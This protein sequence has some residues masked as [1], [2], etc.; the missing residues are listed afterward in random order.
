MAN[1]GKFIKTNLRFI[2]L[3]ICLVILI[4]IG[5]FIFVRN[6]RSDEID[7][8]RNIEY[9]YFAMYSTENKVGVINSQG[10]IIVEPNYIDIYIPNPEK[11]VF[12]CFSTETEYVILNSANE[13]LFGD[14][15][16]VI[17]LQTSEDSLDFEKYVLRFK[18]DNKYGLINLDGEIVLDAN[19]DS[20][21][22]LEYKPGELLVSQNGKYGVVTS[23]G[24]LKIKIEYDSIVGDEFYEENEKYN[25]TGYI[26]GTETD[27]GFLYGYLDS[28]GNKVLDNDFESI[29]RV[30]KYNDTE[31]YLI[32]MNNG[33]RGVYKNNREIISQNY[34]NII[35]AE[36][37][38]IF[39]VRRNS[40][41]GIFNTSGDEIL[42]VKYA[43]Y[44]L[45]G[46]YISA[47]LDDGTKEL[48][49]VNGNKI[50]NLNYTSI[51]SAGTSGAY[52]AIDSNGYY[53]IIMQGETL[54]NNYTYISYAFDNYF[55]FRNESGLYGVLNIYSGV[56]IEPQYALMLVIDGK[57]AIEGELADGTMD[58]YT[59]SLEKVISMSNAVVENIDENYTRIYNYS[60]IE[61]INKNGE[62]VQ[63]TEF[64][65]D[66][67]LYA[68]NENG[69]WGYKNSDGEIIVDAEYDFVT[70]LNQYG[71][72]GV[73]KERKMG[74]YKLRRKL[75]CRMYISIRNILFAKF[76]WKI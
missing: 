41:Y 9:N 36:S 29:T 26:V 68:F 65:S 51:E 7:V 60:D 64:Y 66:R 63:N 45:A 27:T 42:E 46:D 50:S 35:Y 6:N 12:F 3:A 1:I 40:N 10:E 56:V 16:D 22:S 33:R 2:V 4:V 14:F 34:Q 73:L 57:N 5:V 75:N 24:N 69:K 74:S 47:Q 54:S 25:L 43:G 17:A 71:F 18:K 32:V 19:Y 15:E 67:E 30:L 44:T 28:E 52:I 53:S 61:Y 48:Y 20:I 55:I 31:S 23:S 39:V 21:E 70:E 37:S 72:A 11:D 8:Y 38:D 58:I 49:D 76:Y 62:I 13:E 59:N